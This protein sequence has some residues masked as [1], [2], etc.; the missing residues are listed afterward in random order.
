L[1]IRIQCKVKD[2]LTVKIFHSDLVWY[3]S[4]ILESNVRLKMN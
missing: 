3:L 4:C 1:Y 2:E